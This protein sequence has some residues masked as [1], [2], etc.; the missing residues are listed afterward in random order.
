MTNNHRRV[1][2]VVAT[3]AGA[4]L[5]APLISLL[6]S[7][8]ASADGAD[9]VVI[10]PDVTTYGP[11][12]IDGFTDT[13]SLNT[14]TDAFDNYLTT[15]NYDLDIFSGAPGSNSFELLFTDPGVFQVGIDDIGGTY[16][17]IDNFPPTDFLPT[18]PGLA[19]LGGI[20]I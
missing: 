18:D 11:Y 2:G 7:P 17:F 13:F 9:L 8:V 5:T 14:S 4:L 1:A 20:A 3:A 10:N 6:A 19:D 12:T 16:S 15:T